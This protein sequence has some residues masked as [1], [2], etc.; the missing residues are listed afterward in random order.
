MPT[1]TYD[2]IAST[3]LASSASSVTFSS[4]DTIAAGYRDLIVVMTPKSLT[5]SGYGGAAIINFNGDSGS[6]YAYVFMGGNGSTT[7]LGSGTTTAIYGGFQ[8]NN[9]YK[10]HFTAQI[11]DFSATDKHKSVLTR[12]GHA[13]EIAYARAYRWASTSAITSIAVNSSG[14]DFASGSVFAIYGIAA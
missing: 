2:A 10:P 7:S 1:P 11:M 8:E 9:D 3:T 13:S 6:N 5:A 12:H 14:G 4:L